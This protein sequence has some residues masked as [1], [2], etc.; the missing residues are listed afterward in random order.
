VQYLT[1][2]WL[3]CRHRWARCY[4]NSVFHLGNTS[5]NRVE[6]SH[7]SFKSWL[8]SSSHKTD[9]LI[10]CYDALMSTQVIEVRKLLED[11][12]LNVFIGTWVPPY[13]QLNTEVSLWAIQL[14]K[15][16][17][18]TEFSCFCVLRETKG[19][20]CRCEV[21]RLMEAGKLLTKLNL[22]R[23]WETLDYANP[24]D[25]AEWENVAVGELAQ[26]ESAVDEV[27]SLGKSS[28]RSCTRPVQFYSQWNN[29]LTQNRIKSPKYRIKNINPCPN[30]GPENNGNFPFK[31]TTKSQIEISEI[32]ENN[33][34]SLNSSFSTSDDETY[35]ARQ[36]SPGCSW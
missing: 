30:T 36:T 2:E 33:S 17:Q 20:P 12:R 21:R 18:E 5:T 15:E 31:N 8:N 13:G 25:S 19:L 9:T 34:S 16:S 1:A 35:R 26:W 3:P 32:M 24:P 14:L 23:F 29:K 7:S 6:S 10:L 4:T 28:I 22:H 27:V 11:S